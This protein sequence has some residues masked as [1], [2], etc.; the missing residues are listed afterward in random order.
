MDIS[1]ASIQR[2]GGVIRLSSRAG[3]G[4]TAKIELPLD[5]GLAT[6]VWV[7]AAGEQYAI[8]ASRARVV[9]RAID[10][11]PRLPHL[12]ACLEGHAFGHAAYSVELDDDDPEKDPLCVGVDEV[13]RREDVL[14]RPL[15]PL[16]ANVGPFAGVI[17]RGD[18]SL[19]LALDVYGLAPRART[20]RRIPEPTASEQ[21]VGR[22]PPRWS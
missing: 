7:V 12:A 11:Q 22:R 9:R 21:Q 19:R 20:L 17:V 10:G 15:T 8:P 5:T 1:L 4:F 2:L 13:G 6:V 3:R 16:L 18:G 14:I